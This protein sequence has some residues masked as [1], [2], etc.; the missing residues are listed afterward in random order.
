[1]LCERGT[2][3]GG[4]WWRLDEGLTKL[5][6][7]HGRGLGKTPEKKTSIWTWDDKH[8]FTYKTNARTHMT[9]PFEFK[10]RSP[11]LVQLVPSIDYV[12]LFYVVCVHPYKE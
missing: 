9:A 12:W 8:R 11:C 2:P 7:L 5:V 10:C 3:E 4:R 6:P 1:M